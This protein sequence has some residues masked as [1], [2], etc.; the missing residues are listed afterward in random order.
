M[1]DLVAITLPRATEVADVVHRAWDRGDAVLVLD[2]AAPAGRTDDVI[3]RLRPTVLVAPG[4]GDRDHRGTRRPDGV[5]VPDGTAA[6]V[7]T[8][9]STGRPRGVVL[10]AAAMDASARASL[11]R[12]GCRP[13]EAWLA[14]LPFHHVAG[15][16]VLRRSALLDTAPEVHE[17]FDP[18][19]VAA[20]EA[21]WWPLVPTML[22]RLLAADVDLHGRGVL[23][24]G[25]APDPHDVAAATMHGATV[26][27]GYGMTETCGGCVYDGHPLDGVEVAL[28][29]HGR[30]HVRGPVVADGVREPDGAVAPVVDAA[31]WLATGD[32]GHLRD[33]RLVIDGRA[34]HVIVTG[35]ENVAPDAVEGALRTHPAVADAG[36]VGRPDPEWG[37][38]V[39]ALVVPVDPARPPSLEDLRAHVADQLGRRAAPRQLHLVPDIP[40]TTLD[41]IARPALADLAA[42]L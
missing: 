35:G 41:K 11:D 7:T 8:S 19:V 23:L 20:S 12:L 25:A 33:G 1:A 9:G 29:D 18:A 28:D 5:P 37:H 39:V 3:A 17:R 10:S 2:P 40:R 34:D 36:V 6:V 38:R 26:I 32:V 31:G 14:C 15:L 22:H 13:D 4:D 21:R 42:D 30:I 27:T 16:A 24:G